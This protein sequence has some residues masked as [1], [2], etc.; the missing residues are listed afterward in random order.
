[1]RRSYA[2]NITIKGASFG[3]QALPPLVY[4]G[5]QLCDNSQYADR[6]PNDNLQL[7]SVTCAL[8]A[9]VGNY[10]L[11]SVLQNGGY[12]VPQAAWVSY[13]KCPEAHHEVVK[14]ATSVDGR[15]EVSCER[16]ETGKAPDDDRRICNAC[17]PGLFSFFS[18]NCTVRLAWLA[19]AERSRR[20]RIRP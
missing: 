18:I 12:P 8:R 2:Q 10:L 16:C 20:Y 17:A 1:M 19:R 11:V 9:G 14:A 7:L 15:T 6:D 5:G 4:V 3:S 13:N